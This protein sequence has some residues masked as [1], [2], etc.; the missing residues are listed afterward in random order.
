VSGG[1]EAVE[2]VGEHFRNVFYFVAN[3]SSIEK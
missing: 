2:K 3:R 1:V